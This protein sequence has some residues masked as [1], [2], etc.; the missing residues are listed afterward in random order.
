METKDPERLERLSQMQKKVQ[1]GVTVRR[2]AFEVYGYSSEYYRQTTKEERLTVFVPVTPK[3]PY[4]RVGA[5][6]RPDVA[7]RFHAYC[8][9][10]KKN[11]TRLLSSLIIKLMT[12][13]G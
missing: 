1:S 12:A 3:T 13:E 7:I 10:N 2:A 11:K 8:K 6:L 5:R 9:A 4:E